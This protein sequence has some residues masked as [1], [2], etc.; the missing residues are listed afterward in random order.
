MAEGRNGRFTTE[1]TE[2]TGDTENGKGCRGD[3]I[4]PM[5]L[6]AELLEW[7]RAG[8]R[9]GIWHDGCLALLYGWDAGRKTQKRYNTEGRR[10]GDAE[11]FF[12]GAGHISNVTPNMQLVTRPPFGRGGRGD[13]I[14]S[15]LLHAELLEWN[16]TDGTRDARRKNGIT[17]RNGDTERFL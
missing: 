17:Q 7:N 4:R 1:N 13:S 10:N 5:L 9:A 16:C 14:R 12:V 15:M 2:N 11:D 3:S 6:H 8:K